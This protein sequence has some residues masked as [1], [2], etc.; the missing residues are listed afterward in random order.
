MERFTDIPVYTD[1]PPHGSRIVQNV[2]ESV[3]HWPLT[4]CATQGT[5]AMDGATPAKR[6]KSDENGEKRELIA[7]PSNYRSPVWHHFGF[8]SQDR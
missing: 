1:T 2:L 6:A 5:V 8:E 3:V 4:T 7:A